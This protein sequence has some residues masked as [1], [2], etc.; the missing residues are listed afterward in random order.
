MVFRLN[1]SLK[2]T[3]KI[4]VVD[5][6]PIVKLRNGGNEIS[7]EELREVLQLVK[8]VN[9]AMMRVIEASTI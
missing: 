2:E 5:K 1:P 7:E 6:I 4:K 9:V 3:F 8:F